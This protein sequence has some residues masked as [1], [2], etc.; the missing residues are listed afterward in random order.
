MYYFTCKNEDASSGIALIVSF[1][2]YTKHDTGLGRN[3]WNNFYRMVGKF[4]IIHN[5]LAYLGGDDSLIPRWDIPRS[6][7]MKE[8]GVVKRIFE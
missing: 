3:D 6:M 1:E 4:N 5:E 8:K 2:K 7:I